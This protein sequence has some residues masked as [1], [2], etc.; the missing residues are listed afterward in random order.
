MSSAR[1]GLPFT[2]SQWQELEHQAL[3]YKYMVSGIPIPPDLLFT[4]KRSCLDSSLPSSK[5]FSHQPPHIGWSRFQ[6]GL[7]IKVDPEP[8]RCRRTDG[9]KWRCSKQ[10]YTDS[11]YCERHMHR[12]KN[13]SRKPVEVTPTTT[14]TL[15]SINKTSYTLN[16]LSSENYNTHLNHAHLCS[17]TSS[18]RPPEISLPPRDSSTHLGL[19]SGSYSLN[20]TD[21]RNRYI[22]GQKE[23]VDEH[24]FFSE[25]CGTIRSFS[26]SSSMDDSWQLTPLTISSSSSKQRNDYSYL[27]LQSSL[28]A[29]QKQDQHNYLLGSE[30]ALKLEREEEEEEPQKTMHH[31]FDELPHNHRNSWLDLDHDKSSISTTR[32]SI[33]IPSSSPFSHLPYKNSP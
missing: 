28:T 32:L 20:S 16:S 33:S 12:G 6:M 4:I 25:P 2:A 14:P 19:D 7:G 21:Y 17:N 1:N 18:S 31:F 27:Q 30:M 9:K 15:S 11:K 13:R 8:G 24:A 3:I 5:L 29:H 23:D 10:A 26:G 22:Y